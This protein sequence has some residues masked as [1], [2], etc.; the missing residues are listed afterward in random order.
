VKR[1]VRIVTTMITVLTNAGKVVT[2]VEGEEQEDMERYME[3]RCVIFCCAYDLH[4][5]D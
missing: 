5:H 1:F 2:E 3:C 4:S